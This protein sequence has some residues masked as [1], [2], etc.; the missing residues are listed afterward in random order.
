M[1]YV[2][3]ILVG[4]V[5]LLLVASCGRLK[6]RLNALDQIVQ[7]LVEKV[8]PQLTPAQA[9]ALRTMK[10]TEQLEMLLAA[11]RVNNGAATETEENDNV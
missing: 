9:A 8:T 7:E 11:T 4:A 5:I 10:D 6:K 1:Q 2:L 3:M